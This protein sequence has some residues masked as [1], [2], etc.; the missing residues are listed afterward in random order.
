VP[1]KPSSASLAA[2][3]TRTSRGLV[4]AL[5]LVAFVCA[6]FPAG[7]GAFSKAIW[8]DGNHDL[9]GQF[10]LFKKLHVGIVETFL[11]WNE[12]A[13]TKPL[14]DPTNP[15]DPAYQWP[16]SVQRV[17]DQANRHH[18]RV[19]LEVSG[20]PAWANGGRSTSW[21]PNSPSD[22][23]AFMTAAARHYSGVHLWI[24]WG[25]PNRAGLF[26]PES[27]ARP[28]TRLSRQ[29]AVAPHNYARLLDAAYAGLKGV[30]RH[31]LVIGGS[32][33]TTGQISTQQWIQNMRLPNGHKPRLDM[34]S[35]NPF[36]TTDPDFSNRPSPYGNVQFSDLKRLGGWIDRY[37]HR[38][39]PIFVSEFTIPTCPDNEFNFYVDA[40]VAARW[41]RDAMR[42]SRR[43]RR[44]YGLGWIHV[45][46]NTPTE[47]GGLL[48]ANGKPKPLF[49]A[50]ARG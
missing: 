47:C 5:V 29:Q 4:R 30:N 3:K 36:S 37:L 16:A 12:A 28:G 8:P 2:V 44:I 24:I 45:Y 21:V 27:A 11:H 43:W 25:E 48:D 38:G 13:P 31:N 26:E 23:R 32:T 35:H 41:I 33:Y 15:L 1:H 6:A 19:L 40:P 22:F 9:A 18:L 34:Y 10:N 39:L 42:I 49:S 14:V 7:A 46:D 20:T 50:F 17:I